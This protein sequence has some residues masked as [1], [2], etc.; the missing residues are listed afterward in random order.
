MRVVN[1]V[2]VLGA[3]LVL[4]L[5]AFYGCKKENSAAMT[6]AAV[7]AKQQAAGQAAS[8]Q[9]VEQKTCPVLGNPINKNVYTVYKGKKVYFCCQMCKPE[10]EKNP[11]KYIGK[12]P[13][14]AK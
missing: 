12:L 9:V 7:E 3:V 14:F 4:A 11:E 10:F 13:Q 8:E 2:V 6:A 5:G 1:R